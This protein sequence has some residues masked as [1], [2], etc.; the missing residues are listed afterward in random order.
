MTKRLLWLAA[1]A[2]A[3]ASVLV[4]LVAQA[5]PIERACLQ[6]GR[7]AGNSALCSCIGSA[8]ERTLSARQM[9]D[10]ARFFSD[11][12]R[13]QDVRQSNRRAHEDLWQA[14]RRFGETA[15]AMCG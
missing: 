14:W 12:Q 3:W 15:E 7:A 10:G 4:P 11:P 6:S 13:A 2:L 5:N 8:A 1:L 9:R